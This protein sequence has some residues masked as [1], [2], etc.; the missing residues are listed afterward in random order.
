MFV[1]SRC[2]V[3]RFDSVAVEQLA[4]LVGDG[5]VLSSFARVGI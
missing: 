2:L 4:N 3:F 5:F 1:L